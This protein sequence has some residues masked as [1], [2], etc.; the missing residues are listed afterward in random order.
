MDKRILALVLL[1]QVIIVP[2]C[3]PIRQR[4][5]QLEPTPAPIDCAYRDTDQFVCVR[6]YNFNCPYKNQ[7]LEWCSDTDATACETWH[8]TEVSCENDPKCNW[9]SINK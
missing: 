6:D 3:A 7:N 8:L 4:G 5:D 9:E 1:T 2:G